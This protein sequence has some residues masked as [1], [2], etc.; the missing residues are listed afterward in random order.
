MSLVSTDWLEKNINDVIILDASWH[1]PNSKRNAY[2]EFNKEH[3]KNA[4]FFDIEKFSNKKTELPHML[5]NEKEW[6]KIVSNLGISN[7]DRIIVYDNSDVISSCR[8][9]YTFIFFGH[10]PNLISVLNGGLSK[11][12]KENKKTTNEILNYNKKKYYS[13]K[14]T[15]LVK[16]KKQ[17]D[18]NIL[19]KKF[20]VIDARSRNRFS[21]LEK[22]PRQ[23]LRSGSIQNSYCLPFGELINFENNTFK[24]KKI[25]KEKFSKIGIDEENNVVFSCG[26]GI[27]A[28]VL[29]LAYSMINDKYLP[30]IYD[31]SWAEYGRINKK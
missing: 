16:T 2:E 21:G 5:P 18:K 10:N 14:I 22:E 20:Q 28:A 9:W 12:K 7:K 27:T 29:S 26:S 30:V 8:C 24:E 6:E 17:I 23:G 13:K 3:I 4:I 31:G 1:M 11:W 19:E 15:K 25:I